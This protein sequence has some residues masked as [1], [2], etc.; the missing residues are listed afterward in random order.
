MHKELFLLYTHAHKWA[1]ACVFRKEDVQ[2]ILPKLEWYVDLGKK[3]IKLN[4]LLN[5]WKWLKK[6]KDKYKSTKLDVR[7][8]YLNPEV[9]RYS[10]DFVSTL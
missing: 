5:M 1:E 4:H 8:A 9:S 6:W 2:N 7:S 10:A 3:G